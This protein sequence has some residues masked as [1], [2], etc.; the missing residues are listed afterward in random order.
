M[1]KT[2]KKKADPKTAAKKTGA[3]KKSAAS[4]A[5]KPVAAQAVDEPHL[6]REQLPI[7]D[8]E[9]RRA[10]HLRRQGPEHQVPADQGAAAAR[11]ARPTC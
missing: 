9:A 11:R 5:A 4:K 2:S 6:A 3:A 7:P 8:A 1:T 10:H